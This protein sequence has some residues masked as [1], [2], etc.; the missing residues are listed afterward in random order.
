MIPGL[1]G[2]SSSFGSGVRCFFALGIV[3]SEKCLDVGLDRL[4]RVIDSE[5]DLKL[6]VAIGRVQARVQMQA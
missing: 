3:E 1:I 6:A 5:I 2:P 4:I